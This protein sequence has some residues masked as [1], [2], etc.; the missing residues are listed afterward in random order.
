[1]SKG[2]PSASA[3]LTQPTTPAALRVFSIC[4]ITFIELS[5]DL[6]ASAPALSSIPRLVQFAQLPPTGAVV[7]LLPQQSVDAVGI[8]L[9][10]PPVI[11]FPT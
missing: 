8:S 11:S 2:T 7:T 10:M 1:M 9:T 6:T 3:L 5:M 4:I